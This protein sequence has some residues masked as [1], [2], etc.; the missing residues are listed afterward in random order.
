MTSQHDDEHGEEY[1]RVEGELAELLREQYGVEP[2]NLDLPSGEQAAFDQ[3]AADRLAAILNSAGAAG[4]APPPSPLRRRGF[5]R[6]PLIVIAAAALVATAVGVGV[7]IW[8]FPGQPVHAATPPVLRIANVEP[9]DY[10]L[11]GRSPNAQLERLADLA[12]AQ[13]P[14]HTEGEVQWVKAAAWWLDTSEGPDGPSSQITPVV[15]DTYRLTSGDTRV[16]TQVGAPLSTQ[17]TIQQEARTERGSD[18]TIPATPGDPLG[19]PA[20][21]PLD[22]AE[23]RGVLLGP[24]GECSGIEG[25]CIVNAIQTLGLT[26]VTSHALDAALLRTLIGASDISYAGTAEGRN[27]TRSEVFI[28]D[29]HDGLQQRLVLFD[30]STGAYAGD[31]TVLIADNDELGVEPPAVIEFNAVLVRQRIAE[32]QLPPE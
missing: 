12:D 6:R 30:A 23:L 26:A 19:D 10:P 2:R 29:G 15:T 14:T 32:D 16:I 11:D 18:E 27:G 17:G 22:P 7:T 28:L 25:T 31:E 3:R 1:A 20:G 8:P 21:L 13:Q 24:D 5:L 4:G 9:T